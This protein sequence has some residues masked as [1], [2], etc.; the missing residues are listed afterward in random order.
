MDENLVGYLLKSL[1]PDEQHAVEAHL[2]A[3]PETRT[4]LEALERALAPLASDA[5]DIDPP[6]GLA[7]ST[8]GRIAEHKCRPLPPAPR[9]PRSQVASAGWLR[10]RAV[11]MLAAAALLI[12]VGG[13]LMP[14]LLWAR[15]ERER[16]ACQDNLRAVWGGL[17]TY[18]GQAHESAFPMVEGQ[19]PRSVAGAFVPILR[20]AGTLNNTFLVSC[21]ARHEESSPGNITIDDL[22]AALNRDPGEFARVARAAAGGYAYSL[23][24]YDGPKLVGLRASDPDTL[25]IVADVYSIDGNSP[26]HGGTGQNVLFIGGHVRWCVNRTVGEEND[27]IY[28]NKHDLLRAG[29]SR[30]DTVLGPGDAG[31]TGSWSER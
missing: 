2:E 29:E 8:L 12:I 31:P 16:T 13:M 28:V 15:Q 6:A 3:H 9:P 24:Y 1:D 5:E 17:E 23:G 22:Q 25:P 4:K 7:L 27:D 30:S 10:I 21:P 14:I 20:E 19:G 11:D 26:N 18:S